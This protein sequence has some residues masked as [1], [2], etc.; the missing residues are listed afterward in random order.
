MNLSEW[1]TTFRTSS[2]SSSFDESASV[3]GSSCDGSEE[4]H[5]SQQGIKDGIISANVS[6]SGDT[7]SD[8]M[9]FEGPEK[10][11]EV[12]FVPSVGSPGGLRN[13]SRNQLD[14]LCNLAKCEIMHHT[15]NAHLD[16]YVLSESSL[17]VWE[18]KYIMK[19]CGTTTL[20]FCLS[21]LLE[22]AAEL[23]MRLKSVGYS[24]K[25]LNDPGAQSWPHQ[26]FADE[27]SYLD[28]LVAQHK[29]QGNGFIIGPADEDHLVVYSASAMADQL[30]DFKTAVPRALPGLRTRDTTFTLMMF[31]MHPDV[32]RYFYQCVCPTG[33]E[34]RK[35][36]GM[37]KLFPS[38]CYVDETSF[39]PCGYSMNALLEDAYFTVHITPE[40]ASSYV[41]FE[42]N[43]SPRALGLDPEDGYTSLTA[44]ILSVFRPV[45]FVSCV[46][47]CPRALSDGPA[48][49]SDC[50][51][52]GHMYSQVDTARCS[53][54]P[55]LEY[56]MGTFTSSLSVAERSAT[57]GGAEI[58]PMAF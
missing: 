54:G 12:T 7:S 15:G 45:R 27:S 29:V 33:L 44:N 37:G 49:P 17:F 16:S 23:G 57:C 47:G 25:N 20:L 4:Q 2:D 46:A 18:Y 11:V 53:I 21:R 1:D 36:S 55:G 51:R 14:E 58:F 13:L 5:Q 35:K 42:T 52:I 34:M 31:G 26:S 10:T 41:S 30:S 32:A 39:S 8:S 6:D 9:L 48:L 38:D 56:A 22:F 3:S 50:N 24:R 43:A 19:T 28:E 40:E